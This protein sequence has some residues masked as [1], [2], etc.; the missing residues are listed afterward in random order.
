M[1]R[2][3]GNASAV[4][5]DMQRV[6]FRLKVRSDRLDE[7]RHHHKEVWPEM[8]R[9]LAR[10]GWSNYSLFLADDGVLIGYFETASFEAALAGM[11]ATPVND[12]WQSQMSE[13]FE[14][15]DAPEPDRNLHVLD[16]IFNLE[17]QLRTLGTSVSE[18]YEN[19]QEEERPSR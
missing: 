15:L 2:T 17:Q 19:S 6:C 12:E 3:I 11:T 18:H 16:E 7:Y 14:D 9:A 4:V 5:A 8:L 13:F 1:P 10:T